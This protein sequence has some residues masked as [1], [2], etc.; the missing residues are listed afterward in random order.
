MHVVDYMYVAAMPIG[1]KKATTSGGD[2]NAEFRQQVAQ[3]KAKNHQGNSPT[4][5]GLAQAHLK[6]KVPGARDWPKRTRGQ[7]K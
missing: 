6:G 5:K 2:S 7:S 4:S 1:K 3:D